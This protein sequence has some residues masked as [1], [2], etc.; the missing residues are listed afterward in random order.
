MLALP[1]QLLRL[2][3]RMLLLL[4]IESAPHFSKNCFA[5]DIHCIG[6]PS[7]FNFGDVFLKNSL[8]AGLFAAGPRQITKTPVAM[9]RAFPHAPLFIPVMRR[10]LFTTSN[11]VQSTGLSM[12]NMAT[13]FWGITFNHHYSSIFHLRLCV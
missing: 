1:A 9:G 4:K 2:M 8:I 12:V 10:I 6:F 11:D 5:R 3:L 13:G 7:Q